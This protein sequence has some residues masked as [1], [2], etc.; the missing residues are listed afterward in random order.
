MEVMPKNDTMLVGSVPDKVFVQIALAVTII[1]ETGISGIE[2]I[3]A[4][5]LLGDV[6]DAIAVSVAIRGEHELKVCDRAAGADKATENVGDD[7]LVQPQ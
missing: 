2:R 1:V 3:E 6:R 4:V 7:E 5:A